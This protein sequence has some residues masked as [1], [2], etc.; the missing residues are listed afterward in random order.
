[1]KNLFKEIASS[2]SLLTMTLKQDHTQTLSLKKLDCNL[3]LPALYTCIRK[4]P[5]TLYQDFSC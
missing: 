3:Y 4:L 1:M 2:L 5:E